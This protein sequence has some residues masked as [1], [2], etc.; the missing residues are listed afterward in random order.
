MDTIRS[1][2]FPAAVLA[3]VSAL[4]IVVGC[5]SAP[6]EP[7]ILAAPNP[8]MPTIG[9][10][11]SVGDLE[12]RVD[13]VDQRSSF[14]PA[15]YDIPDLV[16]RSGVTTRS[17]R[18]SDHGSDSDSDSDSGSGSHGGSGSE[19]DSDRGSGS[20]SDSGASAHGPHPTLADG[21]T[22]TPGDGDGDSGAHGG[23]DATSAS[24]GDTPPTEK[25]EAEDGGSFGV[26]PASVC[27]G[28]GQSVEPG[29]QL[30]IHADLSTVDASGYEPIPGLN[31][32]VVER[33]EGDDGNGCNGLMVKI[34]WVFQ[35]PENERP[36]SIG[37]NGADQ[38]IQDRKVI[39]LGAGGGEQCEEY[40][41]DLMETALGYWLQTGAVFTNRR[42]VSWLDTEIRSNQFDPCA[43]LSWVT[44][45]LETERLEP[46]E[47]V[48]FFHGPDLVT[49]PGPLTASK[50][51]NVTRKG[52]DAVSVGVKGGT[53][54]DTPTTMVD[55]RLE[56]DKLVES[57]WEGDDAYPRL[58]FDRQAVP[59][60]SVVGYLGN[61]RNPAYDYKV[62][63]NG[64]DAV[65]VRVPV[66]EGGETYL[67][68]RIG[69]EQALACDAPDGEHWTAKDLLSG[70]QDETPEGEPANRFEADLGLGGGARTYATDSSLSGG[71]EELPDE[72]V[73][74]FG[75]YAMSTRGPGLTVGNNYSGYSV[76]LGGPVEEAE[77]PVQVSKSRW[78]DPESLKSWDRT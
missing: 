18:S 5:S 32:L 14:D 74:K 36:S 1:R 72:A 10:F 37:L 69:G 66:G 75:P 27:L 53:S 46:I 67:N 58:D 38:S 39:D 56:G 65:D 35:L 21:T 31:A 62:D 24:E 70:P 54:V 59:R 33:V 4:L 7:E 57:G 13:D 20:G 45:H 71:G 77:P 22:V 40:N 49:D 2:R 15:D 16:D 43:P 76:T 28:E 34:L 23:A 19:P 73:I 6:K 41:L 47:T 61:A 55:Y 30:T 11:V 48:V 64:Y 50:V 51:V 52:A 78:P 63:W 44:L 26:I 68:C 29:V 60:D 42:D 25:L 17:D 12:V 8:N 9:D 3:A